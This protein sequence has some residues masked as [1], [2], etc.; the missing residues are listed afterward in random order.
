MQHSTK[1][2]VQTVKVMLSNFIT[3]DK[4]IVDVVLRVENEVKTSTDPKG[5]IIVAERASVSSDGF[6]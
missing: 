5:E 6:L 3:F 4:R 1:S 2:K